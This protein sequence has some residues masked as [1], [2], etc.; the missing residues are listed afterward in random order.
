MDV[1]WA[2]GVETAITGIEKMTVTKRGATRPVRLLD[3]EQRVVQPYAKWLAVHPCPRRLWVE[4]Y[5]PASTGNWHVGFI[6]L[7]Q[8][9]EVLGIA[10][11]GPGLR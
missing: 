1:D 7:P 10:Y 4:D 8:R 6:F 5:E 9:N 2:E 11:V 3:Y